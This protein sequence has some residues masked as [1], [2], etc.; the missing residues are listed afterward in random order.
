MLISGQRRDDGKCRILS[1]VGVSKTEFGLV[2]GF[3]NHLQVV[4]T[5]NYNTLRISVIITYK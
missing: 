3:I 5:I 4:T 1:R 2:I